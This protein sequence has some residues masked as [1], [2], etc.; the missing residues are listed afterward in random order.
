MGRFKALR[1]KPSPSRERNESVE[2]TS[3]PEEFAT[4]GDESLLTAEE[5]SR[6]LRVHKE[7]IYRWVTRRQI[8]FVM[9][10]RGLRFRKEAVDQWLA[11]RSSTGRAVKR[12]IYLEANIDK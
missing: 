1:F 7:T 2:E 4:K 6:Y 5:I 10:P 8:P 12:G 9:L 11:K 3:S